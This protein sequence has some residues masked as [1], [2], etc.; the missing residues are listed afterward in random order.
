MDQVIKRAQ[1]GEREAFAQLVRQYQGAI[2]LYLKRVTGGQEAL[3]DDLAQ[4]TFLKA[5]ECLVSY[6]GKGS[7]EGWLKRIA[8]T[9]FLMHI[10]KEK[11]V[12]KIADAVDQEAEIYDQRTVPLS[13]GAGEKLDLDRALAQL[14]GTERLC[15][16]MCYA[17]GYTQADVASITKL[18]LGTVKS[19]VLRGTKKMKAYLAQPQ[20]KERAKPCSV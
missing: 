12:R 19:H 18:P 15:V 13:S 9:Q 2:R 8:T 11:R 16:V 10:R 4:E 7:F 6:T 3:A 20:M 14:K 5:F 17:G 1:T